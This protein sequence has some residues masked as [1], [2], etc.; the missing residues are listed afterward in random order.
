MNYEHNPTKQN[1]IIYFLIGFLLPMFLIVCVSAQQPT[2]KELTEQ[3]LDT[4]TQTRETIS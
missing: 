4:I 3:E 1:N 2:I